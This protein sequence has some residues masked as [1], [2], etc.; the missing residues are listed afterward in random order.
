MRLTILLH[1]L[2]TR[3]QQMFPKHIYSPHIPP[4][5][6]YMHPRTNETLMLQGATIQCLLKPQTKKN[7]E[8]NTFILKLLSFYPHYTNIFHWDK[9]FL[10][11]IFLL[12]MV[13]HR[14]THSIERKKEKRKKV[15]CLLVVF[16]PHFIHR[17][18][19][20]YSV[21]YARKKSQSQQRTFCNL[22]A[23]STC[24]KH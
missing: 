13:K 5:P 8:P 9:A 24:R 20:L 11:Y 7:I 23:Y 16:T 4:P 19:F 2:H 15:H 1:E 14:Q 21:E 12:S 10:F 17:G 3:M 6:H 18:S 22:M